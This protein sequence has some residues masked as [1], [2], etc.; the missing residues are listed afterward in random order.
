MNLDF[1]RGIWEASFA[2]LVTLV[3]FQLHSVSLNALSATRVILLILPN[4][5]HAKSAQLARL[6]QVWALHPVV[7]VPWADMLPALDP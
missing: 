5:Q 7:L 2:N 4:L 3:A 1:T 6:V